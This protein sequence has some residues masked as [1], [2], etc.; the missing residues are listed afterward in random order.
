MAYARTIRDEP[1]VSA[2]I[3][4]LL[5]TYPRFD[6]EWMGWTWRLCR[7]PLRDA[8]RVPDIDPPTYLIK[9]P[10]FSAYGLPGPV[11]ILYEFDDDEIRFLAIKVS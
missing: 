8:T 2:A 6:E 4:Q 11:T 5:K 1:A 10:D 7:D 3:D 9:T